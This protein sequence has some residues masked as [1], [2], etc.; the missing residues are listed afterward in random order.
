V[1]D[2]VRRCPDITVAR[3]ELGWEPTTPLTAGLRHTLEHWT[4]T[5]SPPL[6]LQM[7]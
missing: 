2:P 6:A 3:R 5:V 1:D 4:R 7:R